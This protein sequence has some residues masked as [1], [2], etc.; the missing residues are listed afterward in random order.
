MET[1]DDIA[2]AIVEQAYDNMHG[3]YNPSEQVN[4]ITEAIKQERTKAVEILNGLIEYAAQSHDLDCKCCTCGSH[5]AWANAF[6][7]IDSIKEKSDD[8]QT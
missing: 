2:R 4:L 7:Y 1:P 6:D 3:Q 8:N 5:I